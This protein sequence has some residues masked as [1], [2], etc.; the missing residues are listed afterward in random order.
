M[1]SG[2]RERARSLLYFEMPA[3]LQNWVVLAWKTVW[4]MKLEVSPAPQRVG[5]DQGAESTWCFHTG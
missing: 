3:Y 4:L 1:V 2:I 5:A